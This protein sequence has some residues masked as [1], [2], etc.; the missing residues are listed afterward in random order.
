MKTI[1]VDPEYCLQCGNCM[2]A[3]KD[4]HCD[5]DWLPISAPQGKGQSWIRIDQNEVASGRLV[6]VERVPV[7]CQHC[8]KARCIEVCKAEA[9]YRRDDGI[10]I[11]DPLKCTGCGDCMSACAYDAI[12]MNYERG[13]CQK[14]TLC[15][16][17]LD[18]G[19]E[20]PRCVTACPTDALSVID[21]K[22]MTPENLLAPIEKLHPFAD[23]EPLI[24]YINAPRP[25]VGGDVLCASTKML[26]QNV[27]VTA[28]HQVTGSIAYD[29]T[30][31][32]GGFRITRLEPGYHIITFEAKG[33]EFKSIKNID[34]RKAVNMERI[35]LSPIGC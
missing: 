11:I 33:H 6:K 4:E 35:F 26:L 10:V 25:F 1:I 18:A 14:C 3:C 29:Y 16:H 22:E 32:F 15:A 27:K 30:D 17:L 12:F 28:T 31:A 34:L 8:G 5:N 23:D 2:I 24:A 19:W 21:T 13:I 7:L 20:R 9:I